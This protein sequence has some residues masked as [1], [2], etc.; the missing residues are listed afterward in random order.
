MAQF[1]KD[2]FN[3]LDDGKTIFEVVM[4][5]DQYGNLVG[6]ANP[7]G[8]SVDGF[9]RARVSNPVTLYD[10]FHRF[11]DNYK[12]NQANTAGA[13]A[14]FNANTSS[15]DMTVDEVSGHYVYRESKKV[16]AY[17]PGKSLQILK[18]FV[19]NPHKTNLRQRVGYFDFENGIY[20]ERS[21]LTASKVCFVKRSKVTG[22]VVN[23]PVDQNDWNFDKLDGTGPSKL[24]LNLNNP[25]ILFI[26]IEWLGVGSVR[27]GFVID[28]QFIHCHTFHHANLDSSPT[29]AY[30][31]T[32][33]LSIRSEI[34][35]IGT[36]SGSSVYKQICAT[37]ISEGGYALTGKPRT[38]GLEPTPGHRM[39]TAGTYY[40]ITSIR[41]NP[42]NHGAVVVPVSMA[43]LPINTGNYRY[44]MIVGASIAGAVW[45]N[46]A[47]DS[48]VQYNSN[49]TSTMSGGDELISG[50]LTSTVQGGAS[51]LNLGE[52]IFKYQLERN[53]FANTTTTLTVAV[54]CDTATV[55][56][57][58]S[59]SWEEVT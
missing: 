18:T 48:Y 13:T 21:D 52:G 44:K 29:G 14:A 15:I 26:D 57:A 33:C 47:S 24:T 9:G 42:D 45:T 54:T 35:N 56:C 46:A 7:S 11:K 32:A 49:V 10:S 6:P 22:S 20:L 59:I 25:Q 40:P 55:N 50:Y 58:A 19:M 8:M 3:Y 28:G 53:T 30:M 31:Q 38:I 36:T 2:T 43:I 27:V 1:R 41:L 51:I 34:E 12:E 4:L 16:F 23:T 5:A 37:V 17:Q 39:T